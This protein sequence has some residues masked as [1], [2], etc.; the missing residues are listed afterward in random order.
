MKIEIVASSLKAL[1][2]FIFFFIFGVILGMMVG[3]AIVFRF[4]PKLA[5]KVVKMLVKALKDP[6]LISEIFKSQGLGRGSFPF[7][8][9]TH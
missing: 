2:F 7:R 6:E 3:I 5:K 9:P 1:V 8:L 4:G